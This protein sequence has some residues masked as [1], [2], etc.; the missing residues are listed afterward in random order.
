MGFSSVV[1]E[2]KKKPKLVL[3]IGILFFGLSFLIMGFTNSAITFI[4]GVVVFFIGFNIHEPLLQSLASKYAKVHQKGTALGVFNS[5]GHFGT[6]SGAL[7]G[8]HFLKWYGIEVIG[9][10]VAITTTVAAQFNPANIFRPH[11]SLQMIAEDTCLTIA[12]TKIDPACI[13]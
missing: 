8:G 1:G 3:I 6:F 11:I 5:F 2:K 10:A 9:I 7:L 4:V 13:F 12:I